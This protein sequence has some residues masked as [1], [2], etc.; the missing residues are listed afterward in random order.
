MRYS[1]SV[2][3]P[4]IQRLQGVILYP[5]FIEQVEVEHDEGSSIQYKCLMLRV[6][7]RGQDISDKDAFD[8]A[9]YSE[10]RRLA[11]ESVWPQHLQNEARDENDFEDMPE[12][13]AELKAFKE[14]VKSTW[15]KPTQGA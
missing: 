3:Y 9:H 2:D 10:L 15:P 14:L 7:D 11:I 1:F 12:K 13:L 4:Q 6:T 5:A 8:S